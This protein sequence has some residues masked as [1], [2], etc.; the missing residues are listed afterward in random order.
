MQVVSSAIVNT[1]PPEVLVSKLA[2][3]AVGSLGQPAPGTDE[4]LRA[5]FA[6]DYKL[7]AKLLNLRNWCVVDECHH[8]PLKGQAAG[9]PKY[10]LN[11]TLVVEP[12]PEE[13]DKVAANRL[14]TSTAPPL[15]T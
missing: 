5:T 6:Q 8:V 10:S 7:K 15:L 13:R 9:G 1:P 12:G 4:R 2:A 14:Y 3:S 11:F